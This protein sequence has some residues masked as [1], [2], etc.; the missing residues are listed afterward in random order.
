MNSFHREAPA[1]IICSVL[2]IVG[3]IVSVGWGKTTG[4]EMDRDTILFLA[5]VWVGIALA[6]MVLAFIM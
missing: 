6:G 3:F 2:G 1:L 5:K 4:R